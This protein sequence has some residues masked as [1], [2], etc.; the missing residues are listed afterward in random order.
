MV[1]I[2]N[3]KTENVF[4]CMLLLEKKHF[5]G[6]T[7][8]ID[9]LMD[10]FHLFWLKVLLG[11]ILYGQRLLFAIGFT[12]DNAYMSYKVFQMEAPFC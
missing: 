5:L 4:W 9:N 2:S 8:R 10:L 1:N 11:L 7:L 6:L 12:L 3:E